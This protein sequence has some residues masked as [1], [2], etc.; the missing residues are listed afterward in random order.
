MW[1][2]ANLQLPVELET[3]LFDI[4][5]VLISNDAFSCTDRAVAEHVVGRMHGLDWGQ[6]GAL[7]LMTLSDVDAFKRAGGFNDDRDLCYLFAAL[8]TARLREWAGTP[9]AVRSSQE[10]AEHARR[11]HLHGKGGRTWVNATLPASARPDVD[12]IEELYLEYYWGAAELRKRF[13]RVPHH[14]VEDTPGF[15]DH[16]QMLFPP[17]LPA[18]LHAAGIRHL[19]MITGRVGAEVTSALERLEAYS[20]EHWW[21][22]VISAESYAKPN[23]AALRVAIEAVSAKGGCYVGDSADDLDLL[24]RY[25]DQ[26]ARADS[27]ILAV[28]LANEEQGMIYRQRGADC[29]VTGAEEI[30]QLAVEYRLQNTHRLPVGRACLYPVAQGRR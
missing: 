8:C 29:I 20:C 1:K 17:D 7:P 11:A 19:G 13:G 10:W 5:G 15:V 4:D 30:L 22:V 9:L 16:E 25:R 18:Q 26:Q 3:V 21:E 6:G 27:D 24:L 28:M 14:L 2:R 12:L 23:P